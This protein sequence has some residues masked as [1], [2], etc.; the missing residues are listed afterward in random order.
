MAKLALP[1][2]NAASPPSQTTVSTGGQVSAAQ[3]HRGPEDAQGAH[4]GARH[5]VHAVVT[6][7]E[8]GPSSGM[9]RCRMGAQVAA[10]AAGRAVR[11]PF[12]CQGV[13]LQLYCVTAAGADRCLPF[14][15]LLL[16]PHPHPRITPPLPRPPKQVHPEFR[17][18]ESLLEACEHE[19]VKDGLVGVGAGA[20]IAAVAAIAIAALSRR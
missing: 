12:V 15:C 14:A 7:A 3:V 2:P 4:A 10:A 1:M 9:E 13:K 6:A 16:V 11:G 20:A 17:Q 8:M 18:A 19:I 5:A